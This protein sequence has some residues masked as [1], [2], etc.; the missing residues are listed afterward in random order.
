ADWWIAID[1]CLQADGALRVFLDSN[2]RVYEN[3]DTAINDLSVVPVRLS[4]NLRNTKNIHDAATVHYSAPAIIPDGPDGLE[5][6]WINAGTEEATVAAAFTELRRLVSQEEV[7]PCD[8][9]VL[10]NGPSGKCTFIE[11]SARTIIPLSDAEE[12]VPENV[13]VD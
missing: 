3:A 11:R 1:A 6:P 7:N 9:A 8:I 12:M 2:Q 4:R 5:V 13:V 10:V